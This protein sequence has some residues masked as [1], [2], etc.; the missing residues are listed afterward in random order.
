MAVTRGM[1]GPT[2]QESTSMRKGAPLT[3]GQKNMKENAPI[4]RG[5]RDT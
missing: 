5:L 4:D 3:N 2:G 1:K